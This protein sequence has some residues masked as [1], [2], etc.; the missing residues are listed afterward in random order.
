MDTVKI[1]VTSQNKASRVELFV[2]ILWFIVSCVVLF[3][4]SIIAI[5]CLIVH[6]LY[7][8][9]LGK[10]H[11]T[12]NNVIRAYVYYRTKMEAYTMM[13]TEERSPILPE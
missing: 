7:I 3:F 1:N 6:W 8:L 13:L 9:I 10:R 5:I 11:K 2:R 4:F 12:L